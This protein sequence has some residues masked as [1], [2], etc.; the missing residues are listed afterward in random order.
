MSD[1]ARRDRPGHAPWRVLLALALSLLLAF[2]VAVGIW[3]RYVRFEP[4]AARHV[5]AELSLRVRL[6]VEQAVV[7]EPFRRH[8]LPLVE[9]GAPAGP[10]RLLRLERETGIELGVDLREL[11]LGY[12]ER[13]SWL[14]ALAGHFRRDGVAQGVQRLLEAEGVALELRA[15]PERAVHAS[16]RSCAVAED[17][18]LLVASSEALL[19]A[20]LPARAPRPELGPPAAYRRVAVDLSRPCCA[21]ALRGGVLQVATGREFP[22]SAQLNIGAPLSET[23]A[24]ERAR[25]SGRALLLLDALG[26]F[27]LRPG[28]GPELR[29]ARPLDRSEFDRLLLATARELA[30]QLP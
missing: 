24:A 14:V 10:S 17:G 2:G 29:G 21:P 25:A 5:P 16:G 23:V 27:E 18:T 9:R 11:V 6:D 8:L 30:A 19:L 26:A 12:D 22:A 3:A 13:G 4:R 15:A 20:A 1:A 28:S 7:Y